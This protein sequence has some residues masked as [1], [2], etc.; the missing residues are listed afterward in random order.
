MLH[1]PFSVHLSFP[2][3]TVKPCFVSEMVT[4]ADART[5]RFD[6][7]LNFRA[8]LVIQIFYILSKKCGQ[9]STLL[10]SF[11]KHFCIQYFLCRKRQQKASHNPAF[12]YSTQFHVGDLR[13]M[14]SV[15]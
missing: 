9:Q 3:G 1:G 7:I 14:S 11:S 15:Y 5:V 13:S 4:R 12:H 2:L 8:T 6:K 10:E